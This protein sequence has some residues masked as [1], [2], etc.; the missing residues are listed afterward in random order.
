MCFIYQTHSAAN[1][2]S[3]PV[4]VL[5]AKA[6]LILDSLFV[7]NT[8]SFSILLSIQVILLR[9]GEKQESC[10][11]SRVRL[12][13]G[14]PKQF[15][16]NSCLYLDKGDEVIVSSEHSGDAFDCLLSWRE[17]LEPQPLEIKDVI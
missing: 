2:N 8:R 5:Q 6:P 10:F 9:Q 15:M 1:I 13:N 4:C 16:D 7:T 17:F 3:T 12:D 11:V 14:F